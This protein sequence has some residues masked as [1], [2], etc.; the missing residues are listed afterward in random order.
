MTNQFTELETIAD[1]EL[2]AASGGVIGAVLGLIRG[3]GGAIGRIPKK[4]QVS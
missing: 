1:E 3:I 2:I 4:H